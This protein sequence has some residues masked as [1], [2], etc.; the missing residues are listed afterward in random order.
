[1]TQ[2]TT[3]KST[4]QAQD[5]P[6]DVG[7]WVE[8]A[9]AKICALEARVTHLKEENARHKQTIRDMDRRILKGRL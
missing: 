5:E 8:W 6:K 7:E 9:K 4:K 2:K 3:A 1:M